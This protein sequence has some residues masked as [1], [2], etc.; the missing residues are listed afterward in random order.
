MK[1]GK[2]EPADVATI[3]IVEAAIR[4]G[5]PGLREDQLVEAMMKLDV[6]CFTQEDVDWLADQLRSKEGCLKLLQQLGLLPVV[7]A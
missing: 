4:A 2:L 6:E 1:H 3:L 5:L 7:P